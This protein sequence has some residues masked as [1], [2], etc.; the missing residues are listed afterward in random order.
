MAEQFNLGAPEQQNYGYLLQGY[1]VGDG[2]TD[3][4]VTIYS[5]HQGLDQLKDLSEHPTTLVLA[6]GLGGARNS[7]QTAAIAAVAAH[8]TAVTF[9]YTNTRHRG[10]LDANAETMAR[11]F[12]ALPDGT[13][14][15]ALGFSMG[16]AVLALTMAK[17]HMSRATFV[18]PAG[19]I[20]ALDEQ[21]WSEIA[22]HFGEQ[23]IREVAH[24]R[25]V[26]AQTLV[27]LL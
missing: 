24:E 14:H 4:P 2:E 21:P 3:I 20:P 22:K 7:M 19:F 26:A 23:S 12:E 15:E 13:A 1:V 9:N 18:S 27:S 10:A 25:V 11:V 6:T 16:G 17:A 8:K 5:P